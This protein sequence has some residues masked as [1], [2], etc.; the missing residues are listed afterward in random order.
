MDP[1]YWYSNGDVSTGLSITAKI[2][3][4]SYPHP[5]AQVAQFAKEKD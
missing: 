5:P 4:L 3:N 1:L 2:D